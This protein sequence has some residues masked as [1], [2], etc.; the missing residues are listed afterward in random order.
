MRQPTVRVP[1]DMAHKLCH[2]TFTDA[3]VASTDGSR[4]AV[5]HT[6]GLKPALD[7][8]RRMTQPWPGCS[9]ST[10]SITHSITTVSVWEG[11]LHRIYATNHDCQPAVAHLPSLATRLH[12]SSLRV[13]TSLIFDAGALSKL[14]RSGVL[15]AGLH[16]S[17]YH[18]WRF[19]AQLP[20]ARARI[21]QIL[22]FSAAP[23][24]RRKPLQLR[25]PRHRHGH[26]LACN[27]AISSTDQLA[28][29]AFRAQP[30]PPRLCS[31]V[32][33][34]VSVAG[35]RELACVTL[36]NLSPGLMVKL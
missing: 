35:Q 5:V 28:I 27:M 10:E 1:S 7:Q 32:L 26:E 3:R 24:K 29:G 25:P 23:A 34:S 21:L 30:L 15:A 22:G 14:C 9:K 11:T 8:T 31:Y 18:L 6:G 19:H 4:A 17:S 12:A 36:A 16:Q 2:A 33:H 20:Q 13:A